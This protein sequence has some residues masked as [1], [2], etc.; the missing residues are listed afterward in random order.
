[1]KKIDVFTLTFGLV[2]EV[3]IVRILYLTQAN[4]P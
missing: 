3:K 1:M 4:K 2:F